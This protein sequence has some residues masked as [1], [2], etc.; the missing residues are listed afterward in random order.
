MTRLLALAAIL[1]LAACG[2]DGPPQP[3]AARTGV[4][5]S[6]EVAIGVSGQL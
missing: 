6:G 5:V 4:S 3:P 2:V 1:A